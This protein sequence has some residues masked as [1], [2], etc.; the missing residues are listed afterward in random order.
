MTSISES[1]ARFAFDLADDDVPP[2]VRRQAAHLL[3][4]GAGIAYASTTFDFAR[5]TL[6]ALSSFEGGDSPVI[7]M[8]RRLALRDAVLLNG[9]LVHGLDFDDTH[10]TS[11]VHVTSSC[12]PTALGAAVAAGRSG[13]E[14]LTAYILGIEAA[15]RLGNV[16]RG[17]LNQIGFHPTG[18]IAA[19]ACALIA[20][21]LEGL[22]YERLVMAQGIVLSMAAGTREYSSDGSSSK[23]LHPGWAGVCGITAARLAKQGFTGPRTAYEG[24]FGLYA[25]HLGKDL[26]RW[27]L[28]AASRDLGSQW[29]TA[30]VAIKP[31]PACQLSIACIDAAIALHRQRRFDIADIESVEALVPEHAVK[32]VCE[33]IARRRRPNSRYAAQF[34]LPFDVA[35]GLIHGRFGLAELERHADPQ[36]LAL[37]DKVTYRVDPDTNYP[38]HFSG[39]IIVTLRDGRR[40]AHRESINRGAADNPISDEDIVSKFL[41]NAAVANVPTADR[42]QRALLDIDALEDARAL[43]DLLSQ[44]PA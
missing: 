36:I 10:L 34:S 26:S 20:G 7:G 44:C 28:G 9:V 30:Q 4:D 25:T 24:Q 43:G 2:A 11:V 8:P 37:A 32:I 31:L 39:E 29:E 1:L 38:K 3:L 12:L 33:P 17:E 22:D 18:V 21:K 35:C 23:R 40:I 42:I 16:A 41:A 15:A 13:R 6:A 5:Q 14:M 19:F 27:D